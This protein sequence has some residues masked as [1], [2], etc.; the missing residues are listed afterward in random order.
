MTSNPAECFVYITLPGGV[1]AVTAGKFVLEETRQGDPLGRFVYGKSYLD[2][3]RAVPIDPIELKLSGTTYETVRLPTPPKCF[4][5]TVHATLHAAF[6]QK[7]EARPSDF[8]LSRPYGFTA[9]RPGDSLTIL[10]DGFVNR[11][12]NGKFPSPPAIQATGLGLLPRWDLHP[13]IMP[14][15]AGRTV[16]QDRFGSW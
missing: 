4:A 15:F 3:P 9:L 5:S 1:S 8:V 13:L 6:A 7:R 2:N 10:V 11:L 12:Q 16:Y 14:A